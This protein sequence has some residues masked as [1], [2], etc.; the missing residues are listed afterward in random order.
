MGR[1]LTVAAAVFVLAMI[2]TGCQTI[3]EKL[4]AAK[5]AVPKPVA[6]AVQDAIGTAAEKLAEPRAVDPG[7]EPTVE[8][9]R[10]TE[11]VKAS[12]TVISAVTL[13][14][15]E[16][17]PTVSVPIVAPTPLP[18][19]VVLPATATP[20]PPPTFIN[21]NSGTGQRLTDVGWN[22]DGS[23][24]L[25]TGSG[26][27]LLRYD[28]LGFTSVESRTTLDL[29]SVSWNSAGDKAVITGGA[30]NTKALVMTYDGDELVTVASGSGPN[31]NGSMW[32]PDGSYAM[33]VGYNGFIQKLDA[34]GLTNMD[35]PWGHYS[36][37]AFNHDGSRALVTNTSAPNTTVLEFNG[38]SFSDPIPTGVSS[39]LQDIAWKSDGSYGLVVGTGGAILKY[40][41]SG[42]TDLS[43]GLRDAL[44]AVDWRADGEQALMVG[45]VLSLDFGQEEKGVVLAFDGKAV[46]TLNTGL[47]A[48]KTLFGLDWTPDGSYAL[49]VGNDGT[50]IR[51]EPSTPATIITETVL[52]QDHSPAQYAFGQGFGAYDVGQSFIPNMPVLTAVGLPVCTGSQSD[53]ITVQIRQGAY[54]GP[55]VAETVMTLDVRFCSFGEERFT[56]FDFDHPVAVTPGETYVI[57]LHSVAQ[58]D[59]S[60]FGT[61]DQYP[62]GQLFRFDH[63]EQMPDLD[64][65]FRTYSLEAPN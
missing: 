27:T 38:E 59:A 56:R 18:N 24:A 17:V 57:R 53:E 34:S 47:S 43:N 28:G 58:S 44:F 42:F 25:V 16:A 29:F 40:D 63:G 46:Q 51:Y 50:V 3:E 61:T 14:P 21:L 37:V 23:Y 7:V 36:G 49:M 54:D 11:P 13:Q 6:D 9:V 8:M 19:V 55:V 12:P 2:F 20:I 64:M 60:I 41:D 4:P 10:E 30:G 33:I 48:D 32:A 65:G 1:T 35:P 22:P 26:G 5:D 15:V 62:N 52:D 31:L 39:N 45:G